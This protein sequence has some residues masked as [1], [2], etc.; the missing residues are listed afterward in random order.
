MK[1]LVFLF[2]II[3]LISCS[4]DKSATVSDNDRLSFKNKD[5]YEK[6]Y[7]MLSK[8]VTKEEFEMWAQYQ[9]H[10]TLLNS[11]DT[12]FDNFSF[13]FR[14]IL[15][16]NSELEMGDSIWWFYNGN[17]YGFSKKEESKLESLKVDSSKCTKV[18]TYF[19]NNLNSKKTKVYLAVGSTSEGYQHEFVQETCYNSCSSTSLKSANGKRKYVDELYSEGTKDKQGYVSS[20]LHLRIKLEYKGSSGWKVAGEP[21]TV[22]YN[23]YGN[24]WLADGVNTY[25]PDNSSYSYSLNQCSTSDIDLTIKSATCYQE[26]KLYWGIILKGYIIQHVK[27]DDIN[28]RWQIGMPEL[29]DSYLWNWQGIPE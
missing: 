27:G 21:R 25:A 3:V 22:E 16:K 24:A 18:G 17:I 13:I 4:K 14:T 6:T 26:T 19:S 2:T 7:A 12:T 15:N 10:S 23:V 9:N 5:E 1:K 8:L 20:K 11:T 28:N 29:I